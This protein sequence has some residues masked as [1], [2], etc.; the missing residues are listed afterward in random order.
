MNQIAPSSINGAKT[1]FN[2]FIIT[3]KDN[4]N[5]NIPTAIASDINGDKNFFILMNNTKKY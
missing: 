4:N 2:I 5:I 1:H 3:I